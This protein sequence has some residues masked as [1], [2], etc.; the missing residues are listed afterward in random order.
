MIVVSDTTPIISLLKVHRLEL[1]NALYRK[2]VVPSAVY[3][4]LISNSAYEREREEVIHC[5]FICIGEIQNEESVKILSTVPI[6][7]LLRKI[8]IRINKSRVVT[9]NNIKVATLLFIGF[10]I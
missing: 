1:L 4:E 3:Q 10:I 5:D 2:I 7:I 8:A 9:L 6:H